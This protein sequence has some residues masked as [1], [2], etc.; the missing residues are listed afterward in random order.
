[1]NESENWP[2]EDPEPSTHPEPPLPE[3]PDLGIPGDEPPIFLSAPLPDP[4]PVAPH[5]PEPPSTRRGCWFTGLILVLV[6]SLLGSGIAS[7]FWLIT[8]AR[9]DTA[10]SAANANPPGRIA[11]IN[12]NGQV[13][14]IDPDGNNGRLLTDTTFNYQFPTWSPDGR[15]LAVIGDETIFLLP[16]QE[17]SEAVSLYTDTRQNPFYLYWSPDGRLLS[18]LTNDPRHGIGLRLVAADTPLSDRLLTTGSPVYWNWTSDSQKLLVHSGISGT[19]ARLALLNTDS[20]ENAEDI[21]P[22]GFF[23]TPGISANGR[24]WA[25][26]EDLG[27][28]TSWL[29]VTNRETGER[30]LERHSGMVAFSWSPV[31]SQLAFTNG[32]RE[33]SLTAWGPL[34]LFNA[35]TGET[36]LLSGNTNL[37][38]FWSP[39]GRYLAAINTGDNSENFGTN[40]MKKDDGRRPI[41]AK[42]NLQPP[43]HEFNL[44]I[45][46]LETGE[47]RQALSFVPTGLFISQFLPFFDQYALSHHIWSPNSDAV[48]L[49]VMEES[50]SQVKIIPVDGGPTTDLGRGDMPFWSPGQ[51]NP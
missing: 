6:I 18:F 27:D 46:N 26:A 15:S 40:V 50:G 17:D 45:I 16:D 35:E 31:G 20:F 48:V 39:D 22:P 8:R 7:A 42:P 9:S 33:G 34:R 19:D 10:V 12:Q 25:Y 21:A 28:G 4:L 3:L 5:P 43:R 30:W 37:A 24:F 44:A 29:V 14:T 23:Q 13:V 2:L 51:S 41:A 1:M 47:E 38:F 36:R 49:S 11:Y 32:A